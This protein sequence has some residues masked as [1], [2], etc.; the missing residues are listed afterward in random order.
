MTTDLLATP[1]VPVANRDDAI[2][3]YEALRPYL[4]ESDFVPIVV[5]VIEKAGGAPDKAGVEQRE[6]HADRA[7]DAFRNRAQTDDIEVTTQVLYGT[8]VAETILEA[9]AEHEVTAI[10]FRSRGGSRWLDLVSGNVRADLIANHRY[11]VVV[12]PETADEG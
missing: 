3:T 7:F 11:P 9:A 2:E 12:L 1:L 6:E 10:V 5:H 8:D 4:L